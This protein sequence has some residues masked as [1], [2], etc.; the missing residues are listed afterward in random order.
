MIAMTGVA[1]GLRNLDLYHLWVDQSLHM[2]FFSLQSAAL[3]WVSPHTLRQSFFNSWD[4]MRFSSPTASSRLPV[5]DTALRY[6][7]RADLG[8][9]GRAAVVSQ[10]RNSTGNLSNSCIGFAS[11][12]SLRR[13]VRE[14]RFCITTCPLGH[15]RHPKPK[16]AALLLISQLVG[17]YAQILL[18]H[19]LATRSHARSSVHLFQAV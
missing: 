2:C 9:H 17:I 3:G 19:F 4:C 5:L 8:A 7:F 12:L 6:T 18:S 11:L 14:F 15:L 1:A 16:A 10:L 13:L